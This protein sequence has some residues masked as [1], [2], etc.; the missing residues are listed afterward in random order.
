MHTVR[1]AFNCQH[2]WSS[3]GSALSLADRSHGFWGGRVRPQQLTP[4]SRLHKFCS[5]KFKL[6][7]INM[8]LELMQ[9][10]N[11]LRVSFYL[12]LW[13]SSGIPSSHLQCNSSIFCSENPSS[14]LAGQ[15]L[16]FVMAEVKTTW[17]SLLLVNW[18]SVKWKNNNASARVIFSILNP[19]VLV[20]KMSFVLNTF[21]FQQIV[22][23]CL[24]F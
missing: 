2:L 4:W 15:L 10:I 8:I 24:G 14:I 11:E 23:S 17:E 18:V 5:I 19:E 20:C 16:F 12:S 22:F 3:T 9:Q 13:R 7:S 21:F 6:D 1:K